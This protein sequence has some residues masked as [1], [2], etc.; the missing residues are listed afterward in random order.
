M[1]NLRKEYI[2]HVAKVTAK[3][4]DGHGVKAAT[5]TLNH[6]SFGDKSTTVNLNVNPTHKDYEQFFQQLE[7]LPDYDSG[8]GTQYLYGTIWYTDGS[9]SKRQEYDGCEWWEHFSCPEIPEELTN[10]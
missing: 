7:K 1:T 8:Y 6:G 10:P 4:G 5:L 2:G 9:W 3:I